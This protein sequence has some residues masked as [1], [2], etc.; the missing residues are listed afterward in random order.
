MRYMFERVTPESVGIPSGQV[1]A[2]MTELKNAGIALHSCMFVRHGKV[3]AEGYADYFNADSKHRMYSTSKSYASMAVGALIG[4]GLVSLD[5]TVE[6]MF[7]E[8][9]L[10]ETDE[11]IKKTTLRNMLNMNGPFWKCAYSGRIGMDWSHDF[12]SK[13]TDLRE[14]GKD[15]YYDTSC[16]YMLC[17]LVEKLTGKNFLDYLKEKALLKMGFSEDAWCVNSPEGHA[18]GGSGVICTTED[19]AKFAY[20]VMHDGEFMGEQLLPR[21]YVSDARK[22]LVENSV[23][24]DDQTCGRGYGYQIWAARL[25]NGAEGFAFLGM[26]DQSTI[27]I[28]EY[29]LIFLTTAD[30]Q[31]LEPNSDFHSDMV[32][33]NK[34]RRIIFNAFDKYI[35]PYI[36]D[37]PLPENA[38]AYEN[39]RQVLSKLKIPNQNGKCYEPIMDEINGKTYKAKADGANWSDFSLSFA[40]NMG[41]LKYS[42]DRGDK[43]ILFGIKENI[44]FQLNEPQYSGK[45]IR[46]PNGVGY[47]ALGSA[48]WIDEHTLVIR[49]QVIDDYFGNMRLTFDF[50]DKDNVKV[51]GRKTAEWF[52]DEY[53]MNEVEYSSTKQ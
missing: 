50:S 37:E 47:R 9:I 52:L 35:M 21:D 49:V 45:A 33:N 34:G 36:K 12:F 31:G 30:D 28:P 11:R 3:F 18:W 16:S 38:M 5:D 32:H 7:P 24:G 29:D 17:V 22:P 27:A 53:V 14:P 1:T 23:E 40:N 42:T 19:T 43:E 4:D 41:T 51:S 2:M 8:M 15:F 6:D 25:S 39:M 20:L 13:T 10:P 44:L 48:A 46:H 26:G